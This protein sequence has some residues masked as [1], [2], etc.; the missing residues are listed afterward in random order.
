M[1][2][3]LNDTNFLMNYTTTMAPKLDPNTNLFNLHLD[4]LFYDKLAESTHVTANQRFPPR[5]AASH[6]EQFFIHESMFTS[7]FH[8]AAKSKMPL[9]LKDPAVSA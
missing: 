4:G 2:N 7:L 6:S 3:L 8:S 1:A 9:M 5:Y